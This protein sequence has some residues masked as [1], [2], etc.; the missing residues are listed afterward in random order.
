MPADT[1]KTIIEDV[2]GAKITASSAVTDGVEWLV[3]I[4]FDVVGAPASEGVWLT[5]GID[6]IEGPVYSTEGVSHNFTQWPQ[7]P[8]YD[9]THSGVEAA[10]ACLRQR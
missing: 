5:R 9:V 7:R 4:R 10:F 3:A 8:G 6:P 1:S 2:K